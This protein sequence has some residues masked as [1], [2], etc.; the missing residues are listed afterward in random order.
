MAKVELTPVAKIN[1]P[2][3][4]SIEDFIVNGIWHSERSEGFLWARHTCLAVDRQECLSY[5][6]KDSLLTLRMT[7]LFL[8]AK[9]HIVPIVTG[10]RHIPLW[11]LTGRNA[12]PAI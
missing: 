6:L 1:R 11:Q 9:T 5:D 8:G 2:C 3:R 12:C 10:A 7:T 4:G